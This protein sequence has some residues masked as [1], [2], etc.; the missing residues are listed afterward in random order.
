MGTGTNFSGVGIPVGLS[1]I[2]DRHAFFRRQFPPLGKRSRDLSWKLV[3]VPNLECVPVTNFVSDAV[4][5][6]VPFH[7]ARNPFLD[8][9]LRLEAEVAL[10]GGDVGIGIADVAGLH[11]QQPPFRLSA[12]RFL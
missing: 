10:D 8:A 5:G 9:G 4:I 12:A 3:P 2:R 1:E 11:R 6:A 7:E